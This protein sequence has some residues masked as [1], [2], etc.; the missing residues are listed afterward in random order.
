MFKLAGLPQN[1]EI[2]VSAFG[3]TAALACPT[4]L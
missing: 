2:E 1:R 3:L 4:Y